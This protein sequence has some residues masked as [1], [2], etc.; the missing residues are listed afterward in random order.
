MLKYTRFLLILLT[1]A[2]SAGCGDDEIKTSGETCS[3]AGPA[4][5]ATEAAPSC[6]SHTALVSYTSTTCSSRQ[7]QVVH[8]T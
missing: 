6:P 1:L 3:A 8:C 7:R 5:Y 2:A 4:S